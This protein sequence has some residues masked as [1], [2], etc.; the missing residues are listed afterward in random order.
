MST[1]ADDLVASGGAV[2]C[3]VW[4]LEGVG[5]AT[6]ILCSVVGEK[7][8]LCA[9]TCAELE[10]RGGDD[11]GA[12]EVASMPQLKRNTGLRSALGGA[13]NGL[14]KLLCPFLL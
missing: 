10:A 12:D 13:L 6:S 11:V 7:V 2:D 8:N 3:C 9:C 1:F 5:P 4:L 14:R